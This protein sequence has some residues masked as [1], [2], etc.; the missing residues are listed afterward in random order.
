M[1]AKY[2]YECTLSTLKGR[3]FVGKR[4]RC[5]FNILQGCQ[6]STPLGLIE[7][8]CRSSS[9]R[10]QRCIVCVNVNTLVF[11]TRPGLKKQLNAL[12]VFSPATL[13]LNPPPPPRMLPLRAESTLPPGICLSPRTSTPSQRGSEGVCIIIYY[14]FNRVALIEMDIFFDSTSIKID[15]KIKHRYAAT[16]AGSCVCAHKA[17][18]SININP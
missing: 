10:V 13:A 4:A 16:S 1:V 11:V 15:T 12:S 5:V 18:P 9:R 7:R 17:V 14:W 3:A 6:G 8:R 2:Q